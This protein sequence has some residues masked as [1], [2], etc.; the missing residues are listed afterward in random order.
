MVNGAR[1]VGP[2]LAGVLIAAVGERWCFLFNGLS[3]IGVIGGLLLMK[4][5]ARPPVDARPPVLR[6]TIDGFRFVLD[7][8][9]VRTILVLLG[10]VSLVGMPYAVLMPIFADQILRGGPLGLGLLGGASGLGALIGA[11]SLA[12]RG[13]ARNLG[14]WVAAS[15]ALF[16]LTLVLFSLSRVFWL[17]AL[18]LLPAGGAMMVQIAASNTLIQAMVPDR[19][20]GRVMAV[21]SMMFMGMAPFGGLLAGAVAERIGAPRTVAFGGLACLLAAVAFARRLPAFRDEADRLIAAQELKPP[22]LT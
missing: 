2:A 22:S 3:Y 21:Y 12:L 20:R 15:V 4:V 6:D 7:T 5:P 11:L 8:T 18:V 16:G 19:L 1:I 13:G 14:Q 17:S 10:L 9:P